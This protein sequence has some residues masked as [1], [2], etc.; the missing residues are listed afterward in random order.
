MGQKAS[1]LMWL[2]VVFLQ[3]IGTQVV[4]FIGSFLF[5]DLNVPEKTSWLAAV[6]FATCFTL[7]VFLVGW[8]G[9]LLKWLKS[10]PALMLR[11]A[12]TFAGAFLV[13]AVGIL[14]LGKLETGSPF[15]ALSILA[16]IIA[17]HLPTWMK[18]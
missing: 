11:L 10:R 14:I 4:T 15:F 17:F 9:F 12:L 18:K 16:S 8:L 2:L 7:G 5:P 1:S 6:I 13:L 3:L